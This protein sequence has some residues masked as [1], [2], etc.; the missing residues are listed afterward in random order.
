MKKGLKNDLKLAVF[1]A[2]I[3]AVCALVFWVFLVTVKWGTMFLWDVLPEKTGIFRFGMYPVIIC[4]AG[5]LLIGLFRKAVGDYPENM[6]TVF[7][8]IKK[9]GTYPYKKMP[10]LFIAAVLPLIF[11][12]S[13][14]PEAGMV[15]IVAALCCWAGENLKFAKERSKMYSEIG[16]EVTLSVMFRSPLFGI[17]EGQEG[18]DEDGTEK[19]VPGSRA[20]YCLSAGAGFGCFYLLNQLYRASEGFPSFDV[21]SPE[22]SDVFLSVLYLACGLILG[23]FFEF[24]E[25]FFEK[26]A[27]KIPPI[28]S[29][30]I[31]GAVLGL[32]V[33]FLPVLKFSGEEQMGVLIRDFALYAP[34]AMIGISFLKVVLTNMCIRLGLKGGHFFPLIFSA[35]CFGYGV[36]LMVYP[37]DGS[38]ATFAAAIVAAATLGLTIRKPLAVSMLL[39]L[40][41]PV[42]SLLWIVPAAALASIIGRRI[43]SKEKNERGKEET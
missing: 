28:L 2:I 42:R 30:M 43:G 19:K 34:I 11:G 12:S 35:V 37:G 24:S 36:S 13:V 41:F 16:M 39:L 7:G 15:G 1:S 27:E 33:C 10:V 26:A 22:K 21:I 4:T 8:T 14:G 32:A 9:T 23:M 6:M 3:G 31:A 20:L 5:G 18:D 25:K 40:C 29:E 38:H 17:F